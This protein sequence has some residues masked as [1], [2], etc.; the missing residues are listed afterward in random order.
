MLQVT[1]ARRVL[2][3]LG[4]DAANKVLREISGDSQAAALRQRK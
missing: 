4:T 2:E 1:E 3:L